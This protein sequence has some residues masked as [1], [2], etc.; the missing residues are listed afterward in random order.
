M[1]KNYNLKKAIVISVIILF[2]LVFVSTT[3]AYLTN[4]IKTDKELTIGTV[5][6][7][8]KAY[9]EKDGIVYDAKN[10]VY[11]FDDSS[12]L[13]KNGVIKI[14]ISD[15]EAQEFAEN[16]RVDIEV[17]SDVNTYFRVA[18]YE[19]LTLVYK[20]GDT[21]RELAV[22]QDGYTDF[23]YNFT[24]DTFYDN[25]DKDGF[26]YYKKQVKRIDENTPLTIPLIQEYYTDKVFGTRDERYFL[27]IG[28][29]I[30]A[31]Q[32]YQG[33]QNNWGLESTPWESEW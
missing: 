7:K 31:V 19:Q 28:F 13:E 4:K 5:S 25:R 10:Y 3:V 2:S 24:S 17:Y 18:T 6:I 9:F 1:E 29:I 14:N 21:V 8:I 16:F 15:R 20:T 11:N 23:N 30:E 22:V 26:I 27:Q 33:A 32:Y 12:T